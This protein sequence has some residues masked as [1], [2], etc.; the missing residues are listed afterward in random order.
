VAGAPPHRQLRS[1]HWLHKAIAQPGTLVEIVADS[2]NP[3]T[4]VLTKL[5]HRILPLRG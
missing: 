4:M 1:G 3:K 5:H 2:L